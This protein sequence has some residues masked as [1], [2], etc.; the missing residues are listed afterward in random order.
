V[1][2]IIHR[3]DPEPRKFY[4]STPTKPTGPGEPHHVMVQNW[5]DGH[6]YSPS[7][8]EPAGVV[9]AFGVLESVDKWLNGRG[10][11]RGHERVFRGEQEQSWHARWKVEWALKEETEQNYD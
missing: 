4:I 2:R 5:A 9:L 8:Y 1:A 11:A 10:M 7:G 6:R 3:K